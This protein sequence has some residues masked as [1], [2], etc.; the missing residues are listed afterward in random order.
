MLFVDG[1][2]KTYKNTT[3]KIR[4]DHLLNF[5]EESLFKG[6]DRTFSKVYVELPY[7]IHRPFKTSEDLVQKLLKDKTKYNHLQESVRKRYTSRDKKRITKETCNDDRFVHLPQYLNNWYHQKDPDPTFNSDYNYYCTGGNLEHFHYANN[8]YLVRPDLDNKLCITNA[9]SDVDIFGDVQTM[10]YTAESTI[11]NINSSHINDELYF[12]LREKHRVNVVRFDQLSKVTL[13]YTKEYKHPLID[14]KLSS[15]GKLGIIFSNTKLSIRDIETEQTIISYKNKLIDEIDCFQQLRFINEN[16]ILTMDRKTIKLIDIRSKIEQMCFEPKL[17]KCNGLYNF[18]TIDNT[19]LVTSR[20]YLLKTDLRNFE[21]IYH[22]SHSLSEAPC[23][24][25]YTL[26][27]KDTYL[28]ISGQHYDSRV[29]FTGESPFSLPYK[30]PSI[31]KTVRECNLEHPELNTTNHLDNK[32]SYCITGLK[33]LN[34][35]GNVCIFTSN[36]FGEIFKQRIFESEPNKSEAIEILQKWSNTIEFPKPTLYITNSENLSDIMSS[37][38][39]QFKQE[40]LLEYKEPANETKFLNKFNKTYCSK[41]VKSQLGKDFLSI[42]EESDES[43]EEIDELPEEEAHEKVNNWIQ[44]HDFE[45]DEKH[46]QV[47]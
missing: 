4:H 16:T 43:D 22:Y 36:C 11:Y 7:P 27:D 21:D 19:L 8:D 18:I 40:D 31:K 44:T 10:N 1:P 29:L 33:I 39:K 12:V 14:A 15:A 28:T 47:Q 6:T 25:D 9:S 20:H 23:Y 37:L 32:L 35:H 38:K 30:I 45:E 2:E 46:E 3:T 13:K 26:K 42:W 24:L 5:S 41:N 17:F 34:L